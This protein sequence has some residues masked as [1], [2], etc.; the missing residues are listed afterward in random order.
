MARFFKFYHSFSYPYW[1]LLKFDKIKSTT[2][3]WIQ[4]AQRS[5]QEIG[6][7]MNSTYIMS[8]FLSAHIWRICSIILLQTHFLKKLRYSLK[9]L[10]CSMACPVPFFSAFELSLFFLSNS[11]L[12]VL[13]PSAG[14]NFV[15]SAQESFRHPFIFKF[16]H[17]DR[18][19]KQ[20]LFLDVPSQR[21][22]SGAG[23]YVRPES[24]A[25]AIH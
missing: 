13:F 10:L 17:S 18:C 1:K 15:S 8:T 22:Q 11:L 24:K 2:E 21:S 3:F 7:A 5:S 6:G 25:K 12:F 9:N 19:P 14:I 4:S 16:Q 20:T 23:W